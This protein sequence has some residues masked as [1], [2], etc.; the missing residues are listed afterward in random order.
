MTLTAK[1]I[2][3][4]I[5]KYEGQITNALGAFV[6]LWLIRVYFNNT[7]PE[8]GQLTKEEETKLKASQREI[9]RILRSSKVRSN[10]F[11]LFST[12]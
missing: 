5:E 1:G 3:C 10:R 9:T 8:F 11:L 2:Y 4:F 12:E 6:S 7:D